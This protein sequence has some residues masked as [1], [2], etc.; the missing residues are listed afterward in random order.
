MSKCELVLQSVQAYHLLCIRVP[1]E[2]VVSDSLLNFSDFSSL[3]LCLCICGLLFQAL[4]SKVGGMSQS[5]FKFSL[6]ST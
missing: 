2:R 1:R 5:F 3:K 6:G 4:A